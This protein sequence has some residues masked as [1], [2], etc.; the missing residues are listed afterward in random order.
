MLSPK[1]LFED[2][3]HGD[4]WLTAGCMH[5]SV[6]VILLYHSVGSDA[7]MSVP[8]LDSEK[9]VAYLKNHFR[10]VLLRDLS[11]TLAGAKKEDAFACITF[12][13]GL[14]DNYKHALPILVNHS[15]KAS[16][17]I[18]S[19]SIGRMHLAFYGDQPCMTEMQL[20]ELVFLGR[21]SGC[22]HCKP[23]KTHRQPDSSSL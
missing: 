18:P 16:F 5:S 19:G 13:D 1:C 17:F 3:V 9:Q 14:L 15:V 23:S 7:P 20:R 10:I 6:R 21:E 11:K 22:A 12:D 8:T 2:I 4:C